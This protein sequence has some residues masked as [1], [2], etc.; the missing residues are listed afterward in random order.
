[1]RLMF[2]YL[3]S[4]GC[5][6]RH[7]QIGYQKRVLC[8]C[9][10]NPMCLVGITTLIIAICKLWQMIF[11]YTHSVVKNYKS[12][13][14]E[15][16]SNEQKVE[17]MNMAQ[18]MQCCW[19]KNERVPILLQMRRVES[20]QEVIRAESVSSFDWPISFHLGYKLNIRYFLQKG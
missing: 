11:V 20:V 4:K 7:Y 9:S 3:R 18:D 10:R 14:N 17:W 6:N 5:F 19:V 2:W 8:M 1:M 16:R 13:S 15:Q 12:L